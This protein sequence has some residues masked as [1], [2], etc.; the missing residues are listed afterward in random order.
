MQ[1]PKWDHV[2]G[3]GGFGYGRYTI[4][5]TWRVVPRDAGAPLLPVDYIAGHGCGIRE[6]GDDVG[7]GWGEGD[8]L[9]NS[10]EI[11]QLEL[12]FLLA[13]DADT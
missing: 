5:A 4:S 1:I 2:S 8:P 13:E 3:F 11:T 12:L 7:E 10:A 6:Y 9:P